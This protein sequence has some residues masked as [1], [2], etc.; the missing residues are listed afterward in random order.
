MISIIHV[1]WNERA[2]DGWIDGSYDCEGAALRGLAE[3][4]YHDPVG[5][6]DY[7]ETVI[8]DRTAGTRATIDWHMAADRLA[9]DIKRKAERDAVA[10]TDYVKEASGAWLSI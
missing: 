8:M 6:W 2:Q 7:C 4:F 10:E 3:L 1:F 9:A 5:A